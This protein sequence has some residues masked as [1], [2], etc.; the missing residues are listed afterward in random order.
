MFPFTQH[1]RQVLLVL[2]FAFWAGTFAQCAFKRY[3]NLEDSV[4]LI[5]QETLVRKLDLNTASFDELVGLPYIGEYTARKIIDFRRDNGSFRSVD[6]LAEIPGV[7][8]KN[9][10]KFKKYLKVSKQ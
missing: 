2:V 8:P 6:E 7:Y 10:Y 4:N 1:E 5:E 9:F 3:P